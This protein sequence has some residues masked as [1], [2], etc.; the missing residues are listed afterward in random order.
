[1]RSHAL[2]IITTGRQELETVAAIVRTFPSSA[3]DVLHIREKHRSAQE[4][5]L[6]HDTLS[7]LLPDTVICINDRVD[8]AYAACAKA[9]Q[10]GY[11]AIPPLTARKLLGPDV[12]IGRSIHSRAEAAEA[13]AIGADFALFGHIYATGSK[14]GVEPRGLPALAEVVQAADIPVIAIG[15]ITPANTADVLSTGCAGIA[16]MS[17]I[18]GHDD[19][20]DQ[21]SRYRE[22][23]D[24]SPTTIRR[25]F[26]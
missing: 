8:A 5:M 20:A 26:L 22:A 4:V 12:R 2:H 6:W 17:S 24:A 1:M 14:D 15:G 9:V 11:T 23:L 13:A 7:E 21:V 25:R 16:V 19:P 3:V 10:L 18:L